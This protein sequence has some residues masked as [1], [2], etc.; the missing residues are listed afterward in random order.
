M[1]EEACGACPVFTLCWKALI[2]ALGVTVSEEACGA[3]HVFIHS[4]KALV[5]LLV[6]SEGICS[7]TDVTLCL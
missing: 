6:L 7:S 4:L 2:V 5:V 1:S 3:R